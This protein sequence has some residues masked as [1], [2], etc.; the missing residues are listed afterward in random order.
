MSSF[1]ATL[2]YKNNTEKIESSEKNFEKL[3]VDRIKSNEFLD[4]LTYV[5][6]YNCELT[7]FP[8][9]LPIG[10]THINLNS[11]NITE[12][13]D[14]T[15][16][17]RL[18]TFDI[19]NNKVTKI[20]K[21]PG[22]LCDI[23]ISYNHLEVFPECGS[24]LK[25]IHC[26]NN[27]LKD[28]SNVPK[29]LQLLSCFCNKLTRESLDGLELNVEELCIFDNPIDV[30]DFGLFTVSELSF[31]DVRTSEIRSFPEG[32]KRIRIYKSSI[33]VMPPKMPSGLKAFYLSED[34][35]LSEFPELD[36]KNTDSIGF[37]VRRFGK[38][39]YTHD[40]ESYKLHLKKYKEY[41]IRL[42]LFKWSK[43]AGFPKGLLRLLF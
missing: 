9:F 29:H 33:S 43:K 12:I 10:L 36:I 16:F 2:K 25:I 20:G 18:E 24:K 23:A 39:F 40:S 17:T 38:S 30:I 3:V 37:C 26:N 27:L 11:N 42:Y 28:I 41:L 19:S 7:E 22:N 6:L 31:G 35:Y 4:G 32:I 21:L 8:D 1:L 15:R 13:P 14:L 5:R 34:V